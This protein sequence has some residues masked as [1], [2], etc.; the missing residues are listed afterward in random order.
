ML[1]C[2]LRYC[3]HSAPA[4]FAWLLLL[5]LSLQKIVEVNGSLVRDRVALVV[6]LQAVPNGGEAELIVQESVAVEAG[7]GRSVNDDIAAT[8]GS[9]TGGSRGAVEK[10]AAKK[11]FSSLRRKSISAL[12]VVQQHHYHRDGTQSRRIVTANAN[13]RSFV[14]EQTHLGK[15]VPA[16]TVLVVGATEISFV[17][18]SNR[19]HQVQG[20]P[21]AAIRQWKVN[22]ELGLF[23]IV[24]KSLP[25][26]TAEVRAWCCK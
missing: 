21:F 10:K 5:L 15:K 3:V 11:T 19:Q 26:T 4:A 18:P 8:C 20:I 13:Q 23:V 9:I 12:H 1:L 7:G 24:L 25:T 16:K 6:A 2:L 17:L 14:V 22:H